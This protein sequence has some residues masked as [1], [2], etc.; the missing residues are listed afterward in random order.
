MNMDAHNRCLKYLLIGNL[1]EME[2]SAG[3]EFVLLG[4]DAHYMGN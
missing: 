1:S 2:Y 3:Q 4:N